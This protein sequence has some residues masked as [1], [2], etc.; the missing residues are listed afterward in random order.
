[1]THVCGLQM[2]PWV[3]RKSSLLCFGSLLSLWSGPY[4]TGHKDFVGKCLEPLLCRAAFVQ[5]VVDPACPS[6][7]AF[8]HGPPVVHNTASSCP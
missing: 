3:V 6:W 1:M 2:S 8:A 7:M 5:E 4:E